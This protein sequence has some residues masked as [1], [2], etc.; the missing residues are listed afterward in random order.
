MLE[1]MIRK[2]LADFQL[3]VAFTTDHELVV[4][5]GP[6]GSGKSLTLQSIAGTTLPDEGR[7]IIDNAPVFASRQRVNLPPQQRHIGYVPQHY[8]LFPHLTAAENIAFGLTR[9]SR[10]ERQQKVR[11]LVALFG[12]Q[13]LE[14]RRPRELSGGQQQRVALAR[15][16]AV[17]PRLL[18]LDEP[19]AA[20]DASLRETLRQELLQVQARTHITMLLVT[21]DHADAFALG[22]K[23]I[24]YDAGHV[25]QQGTRE[26]VFFHPATRR[27]AEFVGTGNILPAVVERV[28]RE[29]LWVRWQRH[30]LAVAP[31]A[32][33]PG[34]PVYVC[35]RPTQI[36]LVRPDRLP[37][38]EREN[39]L[40][41]YL[42]NERMER[43]T[44]TLHWRLDDSTSSYDLEIVLPAYVYYRL[45]LDTEKRVMVELRR[46][47]LHVITASP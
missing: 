31:Q 27:V 37:Q 35:V 45:S 33:S 32:L 21:H 30:L 42:V 19:F 22:Q 40:H 8:A 34:A 16:L 41:G 46:Q 6:S 24:V 36:L 26:E 38:R 15:A 1:V 11:E 2:R 12:L 14:Q 29:T 13:G 10:R 39:I 5:F 17:Q 47:G 3:D 4:L 23:I 7:I 20:L 25:I 18:L 43:E 28:E 9:Q 44:Y